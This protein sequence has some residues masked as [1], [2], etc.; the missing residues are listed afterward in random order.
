MSNMN[1]RLLTILLP[2]VLVILLLPNAVGQD[3]VYKEIGPSHQECQASSSVS[4]SWFLYN[5]YSSS[6]LVEVSTAPSSGSG[7]D[8]SF[9]RDIGVIH[10]GE[11]MFINL[12]ISASEDISSKVVNQTVTL[13]LTNLD[14][15]TEVRTY[16]SQIE[17]KMIHAWGIIAPGKNKLL[18]RFDNPLPEPLNS[19]YA[20]F[21]LNIGIWAAIALFIAFVVDPTVHFFTKKTK[22]NLD[23]RVL[24]IL[25]KPIFALV[26]IFGIVS[27]LSILQ[28]TESEVKVIFEIYGIFLIAILTFIVYKVFKEILIY[29]GKRWAS[30]TSTEIDDVLIPVIDK[31][32]GLVIIIFG[33]IAMVNYLGYDITFL[34]AGVGVFGLVIA[35]AAQDALSNFFS[36][37]FLLLDRPFV[38]GDYI[39]LSSGELCRVE[40]IGIRSTRLYDT[41]ENDYVILPNNKL[42]NDKIV[43][44]DE[45]DQQGIT[46]V[47]VGVAYG[48]DI[49]KVERI[50]L[51]V[52]GKNTSVL[53]DPGKEPVVRLQKF[54]ESALNVVAYFWIDNFMNK[55]RVAHEVRKGIYLRFEKEGIEIPSPKRTV[56]VKEM[57]RQ[58]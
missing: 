3:I 22:T 17:T 18:G 8:S 38:E 45:P 13:V 15:A 57:P 4:Y 20:T 7:W 50:I 14:N 47:E 49:D 54:G 33:A 30:K 24:K 51:E 12:T 55:W 40:K 44:M 28:L 31:V 43:N 21:V 39:T 26:I 10:P 23:D 16:T 37:I 5:N 42:V 9:N 46:S 11:S 41:F 36:G 34:L 2:L 32:G 35:F 6:Y 48:T 53:K 52:V 27:S 58:K 29:L 1:H 56:Y 25:R 19:N